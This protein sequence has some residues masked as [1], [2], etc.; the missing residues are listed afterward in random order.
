MKT[1]N[2][3]R[4][5]PIF[6]SS[7]FL[8]ME[9]ERDYLNTRIIPKLEDN[10][11][12]Y[13]VDFK[14]I[15]LRW[16]VNTSA[17]PEQER[18]AKVL[19]VCLDS[20]VN[21]R[22]FFIALLGDRYGW[23]PPKD[24]WN[25]VYYSLN[26][27]ERKLLEDTENKS[28]TE[29]EIILGAIGNPSEI[30]SR[31]LFFFRSSASYEGMEPEILKNYREENQEK[32]IKLEQL[33]KKIHSLCQEN[34]Y[35]NAIHSYTL[36]WES[37][38]FRGL[39]QWGETLYENI[40]REVLEEIN[41]SREIIPENWYEEEALKLDRFVNYHIGRFTGRET[42]L[43]ETADFLQNKTEAKIL[44]S[45]SGAGKSAFMCKLYT[46]LRT[47]SQSQQIILFHSAGISLLSSNA[48]KMLQR[49]SLQLSNELNINYTEISDDD[50]EFQEKTKEQFLMLIE[51]ARENKLKIIILVDALDRFSADNLSRYMLWLPKNI[52]LICTSVPGF[53]VAPLKH[54]THLLTQQMPL[55]TIHEAENMLSNICSYYNKELYPQ[56]LTA[57]LEKRHSDG[58]YACSS[59]LWLSLISNILFGLDGDDFREMRGRT[60]KSNEEK[61]IAF[62]VEFV[63]E[64]SAA[65]G[66]L[67]M[68]LLEK[69]R[70][71]FGS[72]LTLLSM[73][74]ISLSQNGL[75]EKDLA[76]LL[77]DCWDELNFLSLRRWFRFLITETENKQWYLAHN[78]LT[79]TILSIN[80]TENK[81]YHSRM[82]N[83]LL[84]L[85][86][87]DIVRLRSTMH[88]LIESDELKSLLHYYIN[89]DEEEEKFATNTIINHYQVDNN[90][91]NHIAKCIE[92]ADNNHEAIFFAGKFILNLEKRIS[93]N[94]KEQVKE[95]GK[96][97]L[98]FIDYKNCTL[99]ET[100]WV[101]EMCFRLANICDD[102]DERIFLFASTQT[103]CHQKC[104]E[105]HK[106]DSKNEVYRNSLSMGY[107]NMARYY[108]EIG[109]Q[110]K[111]Q[112]CLDKI[113]SLDSSDTEA[114]IRQAL[115]YFAKVEVEL[116][117]GNFEAAE[118]NITKYLTI[119][120]DAYTN[121][122]SNER[123]AH[124]LVITLMQII[125]F[126]KENHLDSS[127]YVIRL[128]ELTEKLKEESVI[129]Y[130]VSLANVFATQIMA[131]IHA[132]SGNFDKA[133]K[134]LKDTDTWLERLYQKYPNDENVEKNIENQKYLRKSIENISEDMEDDQEESFN[135]NDMGIVQGLEPIDFLNAFQHRIETSKISN[136]SKAYYYDIIDVLRNPLYF[137]KYVVKEEDGSYTID[138]EMILDDLESGKIKG[139][140]SKNK[141]Q[142]RFPVWIVICIVIILGLIAYIA[143]IT[144]NGKDKNNIPDDKHIET[145]ATTP[146]KVENAAIP[147]QPKTAI[148]TKP[149]NEDKQQPEKK[150]VAPAKVV[151]KDVPVQPVAK[152]TEDN[153]HTEES[154]EQQQKQQPE[155][156][157][158]DISPS[159]DPQIISKKYNN[160]NHYYG[161]VN[162]K[163]ERHGQGTYTWES[164]NKYVGEWVNDK[165]TGKGTYY[166]TEG[167]TY[168]GEFR[169]LKFHGKGTYIFPDGK[170][171][172][173]IWEDG[174]LQKLKK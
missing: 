145:V 3:W 114:I 19:K 148:P 140:N 30:L 108:A 97:F 50:P 57:I 137:K 89:I 90:I 86:T 15:D 95:I 158:T 61:M 134:F 69:A 127:E 101:A 162:E 49:W 87:T 135:S 104:L 31:S 116:K 160:G 173:G 55:F 77:P 146:E 10:F 64:L 166:S 141:P 100:K 79:E 44:T 168:E 68:N 161:Y 123:F 147:T 81:K 94:H 128:Y 150:E 41:D 121:N 29:L 22:P 138:D 169:D 40:S 111:S 24:R 99:T 63:K 1:Q 38:K 16:G 149:T 39:E 12:K 21:N 131:Q 66:E 120:G 70:K 85:P 4:T 152:I 159:N 105:H 20:V 88:H 54:H 6:I 45:F 76:G 46:N 80:S 25:S 27:D 129:D 103:Y 174:N 32:Q 5:F 84:T 102:T 83:Y 53:E 62:F 47:N 118:E 115:F 172:N 165:G 143:Y 11:A 93:Y 92:H 34:G 82:A 139:T 133:Y 56:V 119:I 8:D 126:Y 72:E 2:S 78:K 59:P 23:V 13:K 122:P 28:V 144:L 155:I 73:K 33:K 42:F 157:M 17:I 58:I 75:R 132:Q 170:R 18:E 71:E 43:E 167:W 67:F 36:K 74:Y 113:K 124:T 52:S 35:L 14:I 125:R 106:D 154:I 48:E 51:T 7:T 142:K 65:P 60:E 96:Y 163:G 37:G 151:V 91:L 130:N 110:E 9:A 109:E 136:N 107:N 112:E 26:N 171:R 153:A 98:S 117:N 164:G 156:T